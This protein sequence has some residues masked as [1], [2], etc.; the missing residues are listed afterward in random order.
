MRMFTMRILS[1]S[2]GMCMHDVCRYD[3]VEQNRHKQTGVEYAHTRAAWRRSTGAR[4]ARRGRDAR[5][6]AAVASAAALAGGTIIEFR[7]ESA[8]S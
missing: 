1:R 3:P 5:T 2:H 6:I 7:N 8:V 4:R